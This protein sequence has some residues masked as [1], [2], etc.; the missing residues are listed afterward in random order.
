[1][2]L[3]VSRDPRQRLGLEGE[4]A[5]EAALTAAGMRILDRRFRCK[6]G[7]IDLVARHDDVLVFVEVK[8]RRGEGYGR[9]AEAV[10]E[11]KQRRLGRVA[12][13]WLSRR[14]MLDAPSRFDVVEVLRHPGGRLEVRH[15][16]DAFRLC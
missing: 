5:A 15:I 1:L 9:P 6:L 3:P 11:R 8:A 12:L 2:T 16:R 14:K 4:R 7:E 10:T 13:V